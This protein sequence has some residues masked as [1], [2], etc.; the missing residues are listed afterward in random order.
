MPSH[1]FRGWVAP[2]LIGLV[3]GLIRFVHLGRPNNVSFD[4]TYYAKD[5]WSLLRFGVEHVAVENHEALML[6]AGDNWRNVRA[7]TDEGSFV[8]HPP[9]G[10]WTVAMGEFIFGV[11]P[12]GWRFMVA[13]LGTISVIM[14]ARIVR[15]MTRSDLIGGIA[16]L[17]LALDG[18]HIVMSRTALLDI[19]LS[20]FVIAGFGALVLDRDRTRKLLAQSGLT[21]TTGFGPSFGVRPWRL[22]AITLLALGVSVKW[23]GLWF[24]AVFM[25]MTLLW[26][27]STRRAIGVPRP[28]VATLLLSAPIAFMSTIIITVSVYLVSWTGWFLS[29]TGWARNWAADQGPSWVPESLRSLFYYHSQ[30]WNFHVNLDS[31]HSYQS[32]PLSWPFMT[33]PTSFTYE[34]IK[35]GSLGCPT[36]HCSQEVLALGNPIIWWAALLAVPYQLWNWIAHRDWRSGA[37]LAGIIAGWLPW[38]LYLDRTI[39]TF[40]TVAYVPF[41][42]MAVAFTIMKLLQRKPPQQQ[43]WMVALI[44]LYLLAVVAAAWWFYPIWTGEV[45][46]YDQWQLRMWMPTWV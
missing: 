15:R 27:V 40:Y 11:S 13:L 6:N 44:G 29:D 41:I 12:F 37:V 32:N 7:F 8:V 31:A 17:L 33:R 30:A 10:K 22:V 19:I 21:V 39:F 34:S 35:D 23:S 1:G 36:E 18:I 26:D 2:L 3:A 42:V 14:L 24:L 25:I 46:P 9:T 43:P 5:A 38:L 20:T 45:I 28:W 4:E 16:G